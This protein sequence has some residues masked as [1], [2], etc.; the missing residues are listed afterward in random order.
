MCTD[1]TYISL[2]IAQHPLCFMPLVM[3]GAWSRSR[4]LGGN[5]SSKLF[6]L[7]P[8]IL[9]KCLPFHRSSTILL[10]Q[11]R[12]CRTFCYECVMNCI[13]LWL[14]H[15][16]NVGGMWVKRGQMGTSMGTHTYMYMHLQVRC[17]RLH[18]T[19]GHM[20]LHASFTPPQ[21]STFSYAVHANR[22]CCDSPSWLH[23]PTI[24]DTT[25]PQVANYLPCKYY[26]NYYNEGCE[27]HVPKS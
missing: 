7:A 23:V 25:T 12:D 21:C 3:V 14:P 10:S 17:M 6:I 9:I 18:M 19:H 4:W 27:I 5:L 1:T 20:C 2:Q 22:F 8:F 11:I 15:V 24:T 16:Y 13:E 26:H